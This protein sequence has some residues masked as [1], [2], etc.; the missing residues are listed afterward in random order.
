MLH[1][2]GVNP[3]QNDPNQ[4]QQP[5]Q[6]G[7]TGADLI[8]PVQIEFLEGLDAIVVRGN[9]RDVDRVMQIINEIEQLST[10]TQP[11]IEIYPL[12]FVSG[13]TLYNLVQS[14]YDQ[15]LATRQGRV[16]ITP[17]VK[18]NSLLLIGREEAV[19][20]CAID[21][22]K[23]LDQPVNPS[24]L[25]QVFPL[26]NASATAAQQTVNQFFLSR[27]GGLGGNILVVSDFRSNSL[28]VQASPRD[29]QEVEPRC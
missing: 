21:L 28:I 12:K 13:Q 15:T 3:E 11:R 22:I 8:G 2:P 6:P 16:S 5:A 29:L 26:K 9:P 23:R 24:A 25:F 4:P 10:V 27:S 1:S 18:P 19:Q 7:P 14:I 17:L 20:K